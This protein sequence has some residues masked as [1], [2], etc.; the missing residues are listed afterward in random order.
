[1][2]KDEFDERLHP[3]GERHL[4]RKKEAKRDKL[5]W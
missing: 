1:M 4:A 2:K 5:I 3:R